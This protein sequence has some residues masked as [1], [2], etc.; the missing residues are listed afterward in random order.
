MPQGIPMQCPRC[1]KVLGGAD[2]PMD[3]WEKLLMKHQS[4]CTGYSAAALR[5]LPPLPQTNA[6]KKR[7]R[8]DLQNQARQA[9]LVNPR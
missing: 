5:A 6:A 4:V 1:Y 3:V 9:G 7:R 2:L 8:S